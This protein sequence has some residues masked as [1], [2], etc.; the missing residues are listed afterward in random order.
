VFS[1]EKNDQLMK[2][3]FPDSDTFLS[4][5]SYEEMYPPR[6]LPSHA[7][8]T[9][10]A[11]SP[12][13]F[14]HIGGIYASLINKKVAEQSGGVF[15]L[16]I[17]DTDT[18]RYQAGAIRTI[19]D[20]LNRFG[21]PPDEGVI[22]IENGSVV[23]QG[24]YGPYIQTNRVQIYRTFAADLMRRGHAYP[25][26]CTE[27]DDENLRKIQKEQKVARYGYYGKWAKCRHRSFA[28]TIEQLQT[29]TPF[30]I[31]L[32]ATGDYDKR[33][34]WDDCIKGSIS[35]PEYDLDI[36]LLKSD[37]IPTYHLAHV[38]DDHFMR[39]THVIRAD[40]W[41]SSVPLHLQLFQLFSWAP[42]AFGHFPPIEKIEVIKEI[43]QSGKEVIR[44]S[45]R[46]LSKR[47]D[48]EA[49][50]DF[51]TEMGF[52]EEAIIEY[53]SNLF[54]SSFE[55]WRAENPTAP[56]DSFRF[57]LSSLGSH[58]ALSDVVKIA[59]ISKDIIARL[60]IDIVYRKAVHWA[61]EFDPE[62]ASL[63]SKYPDYTRKALDIERTG[64]TASKRIRT[65]RDIR[66][67]LAFMYDELFSHQNH[68]EFPENMT[69]EE[70][71]T[72]LKR[73]IEVYNEKDDNNVQ[74]ERYK[75]I[76]REIG[77]ADSV[78]AFKKAKGAF[79]GHVGDVAMV[80][81]VALCGSRQSP[82]LWE[83]MQVMGR[84]RIEK[85]LARNFA[86]GEITT[87]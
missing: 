8:V 70:I 44:E 43:D 60:E 36:V 82:G 50:I 58:G 19:I 32:R 52:P 35:M 81:R 38:V 6:N 86:K 69:N 34:V 30:V 16:R 87:R 13:G 45:R 54:D 73:F 59:S 26:F 9:R 61:R 12:T 51:Y 7:M 85:R 3:V 40:E 63:M 62:L 72:V 28:D 39:T 79:R 20:G 75:E 76:A 11:P 80:L 2:L 49:N 55:P 48:P 14:M 29:G 25:C 57:D 21:L 37:G 1:T 42:P 18:E 17:E 31:R 53:L 10:F 66:P 78:G 41:L 15:F 47:N 46:K 33:I 65:W 67:Q 23:E 24:N 71:R 83:I 74:F 84:E 77:F 5:D 64:E 68:F 56:Y 22:G 27:E 4:T